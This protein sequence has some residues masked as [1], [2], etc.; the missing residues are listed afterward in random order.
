MA[1]NYAIIPIHKWHVHDILDV[2]PA[3]SPDEVIAGL[4]SQEKK[5]GKRELSKSLY[6]YKGLKE[7]RK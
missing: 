4:S 7:E 3:T 5:I 2:R 6:G 1:K